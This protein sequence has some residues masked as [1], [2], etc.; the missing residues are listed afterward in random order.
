MESDI[1]NNDVLEYLLFLMIF[2]YIYIYINS[3]KES[4]LRTIYNKDSLNRI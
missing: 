3:M 1:M 4:S 2:K